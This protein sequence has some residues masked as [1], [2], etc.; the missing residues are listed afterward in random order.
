MRTAG[1]RASPASSPLSEHG[2]FAYSE[3]SRP[4][5]KAMNA[6]PH[7]RFDSPPSGCAGW[8]VEQRRS[9]EVRASETYPYGFQLGCSVGN[10]ISFLWISDRRERRADHRALVRWR[11]GRC[12][13][14]VPPRDNA[15]RTSAGIE[16]RR[17][18]QSRRASDVAE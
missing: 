3:P 18:W 12:I 6:G 13:L 2:R 15:L 7:Y 4:S 5:E 14:A 9:F 17:E 1:A 11:Q 10:V 16:R 8:S